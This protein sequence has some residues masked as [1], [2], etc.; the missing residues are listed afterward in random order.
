M[1]GM[2][3]R[4]ILTLSC[5]LFLFCLSGCGRGNQ[6]VGSAE[7]D[8]ASIE[9]VSKARADAFNHGDAAAIAAH[10]AEGALLM[11]P[12][13]PVQVGREAVRNYYQQI[14]DE[15]NT[16]LKSHYEEVEVSGDQAYGR[17]FAEV[18]LTPKRGGQAL[19][20]TAK[21]INILKRQRDGTWKTTHDIWNGNEPPDSSVPRPNQ[22]DK[23]ANY[24]PAPA[25]H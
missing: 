9:A 11:A 10:F 13:K 6:I 23:T 3:S 16:G 18:I 19:K 7:Q 8:I 2:M 4:G 14:F 24:P 17:G 5:C 1:L 25:D 20:S 22:T 21:Y 15:Y 12:D